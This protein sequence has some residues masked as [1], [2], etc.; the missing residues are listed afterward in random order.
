MVTRMVVYLGFFK[1]PNFS[2]SLVIEKVSCWRFW[3]HFRVFF[4]KEL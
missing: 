1:D 4:L 3:F 2:R